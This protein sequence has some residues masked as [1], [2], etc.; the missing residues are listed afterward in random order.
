MP[1]A[2]EIPSFSHFVF[3]SFS[4]LLPR[5]ER[6]KEFLILDPFFTWSCIF[7][8]FSFSFIFGEYTFSFL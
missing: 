5:G 1:K 6:I 7:L 2:R 8:F 3:C 4:S